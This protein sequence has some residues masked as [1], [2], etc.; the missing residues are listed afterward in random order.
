MVGPA[1]T[2]KIQRLEEVQAI[3]IGPVA[4]LADDTIVLLP[5]DPEWPAMF[6]REAARVRGGL[7]DCPWPLSEADHCPGPGRARLVRRA[8]VRPGHGGRGLHPSD[9]R[10]RLVRA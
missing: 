10:A 9:P 1:M 3:T 8:G 6:E 5:Y 7:G 4:R 2:S